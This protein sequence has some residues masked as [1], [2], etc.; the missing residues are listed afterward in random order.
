MVPISSE[1]FEGHMQM[2]TKARAIGRSVGARAESA[3]L[4]RASSSHSEQARR[5]VEEMKAK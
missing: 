2:G 5:H 1:A 3:A 4:V